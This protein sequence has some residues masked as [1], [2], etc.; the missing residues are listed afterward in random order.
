MLY[1]G[2]KYRHLV[3]TVPKALH[4]WFYRHSA[5]LH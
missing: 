3:L 2:V 1:E 4:M 5:E